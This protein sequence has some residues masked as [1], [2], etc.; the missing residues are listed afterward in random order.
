MTKKS[1]PQDEDAERKDEEYEVEIFFGHRLNLIELS[2]LP[3]ALGTI[4]MIVH[5]N[6]LSIL[7][8]LRK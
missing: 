7:P 8:M 6:H 4:V 1:E 3:N 2:A 5:G